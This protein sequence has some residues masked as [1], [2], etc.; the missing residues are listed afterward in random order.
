MR[1][2]DRDKAPD[3]TNQKTK[4]WRREPTKEKPK[5]LNEDL[6]CLPVHTGYQPRAGG[7]LSSPVLQT[8]DL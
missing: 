3:G 6:T 1:P 5:E 2:E 8:N 7:F 4:P